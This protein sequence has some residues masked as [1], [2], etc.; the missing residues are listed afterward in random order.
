MPDTKTKCMVI[1]LDGVSQTLLSDYMEKGYL[2]NLKRIIS[3]G[4]KLNQM[5]ASVPDVSSTSWTSFMTGVNPGEHGI[6][7]FMELSPNSYRMVFPNSKDV[8]GPAIWEILA[9]NS[10][11]KS[12][13]LHGRF[14]GNLNGPLKSIVLNIPQTYPAEPMNGILTA[15]FVCPDLK[16]G[17]YPETAYN[18]LKS[19]GF[20]SDVDSNKAVENPPA[21]FDE[22]FLA[23]EKRAAAYEHFFANE[24]WSLF[25][26]V[27]TETDRLHHF[28]FDAAYDAGHRYHEVFVRFYRKMDEVIGKLFDRFME[29]TGGKGLFMTMSDHGFTVLRQEVYINVL[30]R[31]KGF[32]KLNSHKEYYEQID[33]GTKAFCMDPARIY[34]NLEGKYPLGCVKAGER[35]SVVSEIKSALEALTDES[36]KP[37]IKS[38]YSNSELY[39]GPSAGKGPDLVCI[40]NDGFDLKSTLKKEQVFGKG[41]FSGMH[42]RH[43]A[44]CIMPSGMDAGKRL[45]IEDLAGL[46]LGHFA[47]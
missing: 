30:L 14:K 28:F 23:L 45:H 31:Q 22:V 35:D 17:T 26:G 21:F 25:I 2:P 16:K 29:K 20:L 39:S 10:N 38:V 33:A 37:V 7:G 11:G 1:G 8:R 24:E 42:T 27:I 15:G 32:L 41:P 9:Q 5:D 4:Y 44:H 18:Y 3:G 40:A 47:N 13:T 36:G 19:I 34:V 43:D 6:F 46:I 12:S